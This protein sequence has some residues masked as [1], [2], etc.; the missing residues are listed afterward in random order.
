MGTRE[1]THPPKP[2]GPTRKLAD[3][4]PVMI[5]DGSPPPKTDLDGSAGGFSSSKPDIPNPTDETHERRPEFL[6]PFRIIS[7]PVKVW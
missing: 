4:T 1:L 7:I 2:L 3:P 6:D 5:G